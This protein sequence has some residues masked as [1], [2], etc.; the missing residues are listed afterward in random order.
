MRSVGRD[1]NSL[2]NDLSSELD[3]VKEE[4]SRNSSLIQKAIK[5]SAKFGVEKNNSSN[6]LLVDSGQFFSLFMSSSVKKKLNSHL[7]RRLFEKIPLAITCSKTRNWTNNVRSVGN[8]I[9]DL[10][11]DHSSR[12]FLLI[13]LENRVVRVIEIFSS[14]EHDTGYGSVS[15]AIKTGNYF[16]PEAKFKLNV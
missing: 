13:D 10:R 5:S 15:A 16:I 9:I 11:L 1:L 3:L 14:G 8:G 4:I 12:S 2:L 6:L 7:K